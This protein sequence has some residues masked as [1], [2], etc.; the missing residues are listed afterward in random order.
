MASRDH[1]IGQ[2]TAAS[3]MGKIGQKSMA[4]FP[5]LFTQYMSLCKSPNLHSRFHSMRKLLCA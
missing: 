5:P 4:N 1:D 2:A 3:A